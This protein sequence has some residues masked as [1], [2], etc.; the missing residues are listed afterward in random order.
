VKEPVQLDPPVQ[1]DTLIAGIARTH[2]DVL[3][4]L[5]TAVIAADHLGVVADHLIGHFVEA[6]RSSGA[7]WRDIGASMGVSKQAAQKRFVDRTA[8]DRPP[9]HPSQGFSRFTRQA[10]DALVAAHNAAVAAAN[11][12]VTADHLVLGLLN[13]PDSIAATAIAAQGFSLDDVRDDVAAALPPAGDPV[14][15]LVPYSHEARKVIELAFREAIRLGHDDVGDGHLLLALLR[16][17]AS[18][19]TAR[20]VDTKA[21]TAHVADYTNDPDLGEN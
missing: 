14:P 16:S 10:G 6:A 5:S 9:L 17:K 7:S 4:Q 21:A 15:D 19:L 11:T 3:D 2:D 8:P 20:G 1:L 18:S 12:E 13:E